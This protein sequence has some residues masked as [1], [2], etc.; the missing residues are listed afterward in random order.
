[1]LTPCWGDLL[2]CATKLLPE[3]SRDL[4]SESLDVL[5]VN[6]WALV[7][8]SLLNP[9]NPEKL[10]KTHF[11]SSPGEPGISRILALRNY[12][13]QA[14]CFR[15]YHDSPADLKLAERCWELGFEMQEPV[16]L[17]VKLRASIEEF[18]KF[19]GLQHTLTPTWTFWNS[20]FLA[21]YHALI[22]I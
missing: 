6:C 11:Q 15:V 2:V 17:R 20:M 21:G 1:M 19:V 10:W 7:K 4:Q 3:W 22:R 5:I 13:Q 16:T 9:S 18:N 14:N 8:S 12:T